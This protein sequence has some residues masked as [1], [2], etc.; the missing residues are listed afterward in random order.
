[1]DPLVPP[2]IRSFLEAQNAEREE[3]APGF[4][5]P[6]KKDPGGAKGDLYPI[7]IE[8]R[9]GAPAPGEAKDDENNEKA[10]L[11]LVYTGG[12]PTGPYNKFRRKETFDFWIRSM[13]PPLAKQIDDRLR[14]LLHDKRGWSMDGLEVIESLSWRPMQPIGSG[15]QGYSYTLSYVFELYAEGGL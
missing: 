14:L 12:I 7:F 9:E 11:S 5:A 15:P 3:G 10:I 2:F 4:R 1:M 8:P 6:S 13:N